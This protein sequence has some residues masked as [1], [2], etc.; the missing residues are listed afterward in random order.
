MVQTDPANRWHNEHGM[1]DGPGWTNLPAG[2][3]ITSPASVD[4]VF[5]PDGGAWLTDGS[6]L[7]RSTTHRL[8]LRFSSGRLVDADG[9]GDTVQALLSHLDSG[10]DARRVGQVSF[11][12]NTGVVAPIGLSCQDVKLRGCHLI[13][14]YSAPELTHA[15]W[16]GD[17]LVQLLQRRASVWIDGV[18]VL[19]SGRYVLP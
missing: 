5:V 17:R 6:G 7:D 13:L 2:E 19:A 18:Q 3:V 10:R 4:G 1:L 9:P 8:R 14:G 16:N 11:G 12:T 15:S